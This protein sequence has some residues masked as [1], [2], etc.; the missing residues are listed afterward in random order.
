MRFNFKPTKLIK[1]KNEI[2]EIHSNIGEPKEFEIDLDFMNLIKYL[3]GIKYEDLKKEALVRTRKEMELIA[4]YLPHNYYNVDLNNIFHIFLLRCNKKLSKLLFFEWQNAYSNFEFIDYFQMLILQNKDFK[5]L[6]NECH[7]TEEKILYI[8]KQEN[9]PIAFGKEAVSLH[10][11]TNKT[12]IEKLEYIGVRKNS[13]LCLKCMDL[14]YTYCH[15]EDYL[16]IKGADLYIIVK[17]YGQDEKRLFLINFL[18]C[19]SL[20]DLRNYFKLAELFLIITGEKN[21]AQF[22]LYF[23]NFNIILLRKYIDWINMYKINNIFGSDERSKFWER[24]HYEYVTK[25]DYSNS[26]VLEFDKYVAVEFLGQGMGPLYIYRKDYFNKYVRDSFT[27]RKYDNNLLRNYLYHNTSYEKNEKY[28]RSVTGTR[29]V[30]LP[31]PGWQSNF[32]SVLVNNG[33]TKRIF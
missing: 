6:V 8:I 27:L 28:I 14:F 11:F 1:A 10:Q 30:H 26:V 18:E 13:K 24:Y 12:L 3:A 5:E 32:D 20:V 19:L 15:K 9:I 29:L 31:N 17:E 22:D 23:K 7:L 2:I 25:Y 16:K 4:E 21:T 33:I